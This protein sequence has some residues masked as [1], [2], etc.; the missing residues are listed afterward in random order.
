MC[1]EKMYRPR[2]A[3]ALYRRAL[4][5]DL[6]PALRAEVLYALAWAELSLANAPLASEAFGEVIEDYPQSPLAEQA[7]YWQGR[8]D[9]AG[10]RWE[11]AIDNLLKLSRT[12]TSS[13]L[14]DDALFFAARAAR[15]SGKYLKAIEYFG[16]LGQR[17]PGT[18]LLAQA[19]IEA[20]ECM[21][22]AGNADSAAREFRRFIENNLDSPMR[23]L[24][25]YDMGKALQRAGRYDE[26][27]EQYR[28]A[29]GGETSELAARSRFAIA[30]CFAELDRSGEAIAELIGIARGG[31][32]AG[33]AERAQL[34][35]A[36][37][38]ERDGQKEQARH[39]YATIAAMYGNDVA[40]MVALKAMTRL[41]ADRRTLAAP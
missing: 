11:P 16:Q 19:E 36:R 33:W 35:M 2:R 41:D 37:L 26:A 23:P 7:H 25:L 34:Q 17:F 14:A 27:I 8:L 32:P 39:V 30:E 3:V 31:F 18:A 28:V 15:K 10:G 4:Q 12:F 38:L 24:A 5:R 9:Y 6:S 20:A 40:G 21:I 1:E 22:E 13:E 29:A